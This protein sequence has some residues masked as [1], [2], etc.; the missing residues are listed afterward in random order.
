MEKEMFTFLVPQTH[1]ASRL[2][3]KYST[4][5]HDVGFSAILRKHHAEFIDVISIHFHR[6]NDIPCNTHM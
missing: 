3:N 2:N 5:Q 4:Y 6:S 1:V